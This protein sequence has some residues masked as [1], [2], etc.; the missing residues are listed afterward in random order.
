[1]TDALIH[2]DEEGRPCASH[3]QATQDGIFALAMLGARASSFHHDIAS[4]LQGI[5][6]A[7]DEISELI[8]QQPDADLRRA[9]DTAHTALKELN[10]LLNTNRA[11]SKPPT[12][13]RQNARDLFAAAARRVGVGLRGELP[14][15]N[16][17]V[18]GPAATL[19]LGLA[20]DVAGGTGRSRSV[21]V[22]GEVID[23]R[24]TVTL[25]ATRP[26]AS[27][28]GESLAIAA[29]ILARDGGDVRCAPAGDRLTVHLP[30]AS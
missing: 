25:H 3:P 23:G 17:D 1:M 19:A 4:K 14:E 7:L 28:A 26:A 11:L 8:E 13:T 2:L 30:V 18:A 9:T 29:W 16:H 27:T 5:M 22:A 10:V 15:V 24:L 6:M 21:E 20:F 12:R